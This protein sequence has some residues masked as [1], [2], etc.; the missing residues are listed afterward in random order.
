MTMAMQLMRAM[1]EPAVKPSALGEPLECTNPGNYDIKKTAR[2]TQ[3]VIYYSYL[4]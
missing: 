3:G 2:N 4:F 1:A